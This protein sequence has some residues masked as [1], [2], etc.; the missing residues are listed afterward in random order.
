M[1]LFLRVFLILLTASF[2]IIPNISQAQNVLTYIPKQAY[3]LLEPIK[4]EADKF[5][6]ELS[7]PYYFAALYE[8]ESCLSLT[9]SKCM[10]P[11]S[12]YKRYDKTTGKLVE[13]GV[14]LGQTT[15]AYRANGV[16]RFDTLAGMKSIYR[17]HLQELNWDNITKR[18]DLQIRIG[19]LLTMENYRALSKVID[20]Q[21]RL[22]MADAAYNGGLRDLNQE[23]TLCNLKPGCDPQ[24]WFGN[25]EKIVY[26]SQA[27]IHNG[28]SSYEVNRH[29]VKDVFF[30][31]MPK[32]KLWYEKNLPYTE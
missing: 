22:Y 10:N 27:K 11:A 8:H 2:F 6:P 24:K 5:A 16:L 31:R 3:P 19:I 7:K 26:K 20:P 9:H 29:H 21:E 28:R 32:Y 4:I 12:E 14:G 18:P 30:N 15:R 23:R 1:I 17:T 13:Q 25:V